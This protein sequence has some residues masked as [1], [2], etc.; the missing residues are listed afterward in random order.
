[1]SDSIQRERLVRA[2]EDRVVRDPRVSRIVAPVVRRSRYQ[3]FWLDQVVGTMT[4]Q[5]MSEDPRD[6]T[7]HPGSHEARRCLYS[8]CG[9]SGLNVGAAALTPA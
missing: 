1:M 5:G 6:S 4:V 8:S 9:C 7:G 2:I 3:E